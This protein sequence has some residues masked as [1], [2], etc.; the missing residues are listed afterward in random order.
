M[1]RISLIIKLN[2]WASIRP[3]QGLLRFLL[4][5]LLLRFLDVGHHAASTL[6]LTLCEL[7]T[8]PRIGVIAG[9]QLNAYRRT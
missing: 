2:I 5:T 8:A 1:V 9:S 3:T 6:D 7:V 4:L